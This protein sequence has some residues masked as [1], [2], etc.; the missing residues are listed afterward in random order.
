MPFEKHMGKE[1]KTVKTNVVGKFRD[2]SAQDS[3]VKFQPSDF[4]DDTDSAI[5]VR[6]RTKGSKVESTFARKTGKVVQETQHTIAT[7]PEKTKRP[8]SFSKRE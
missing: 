8:K 3:Q 6:E 5:L 4:H 2:F 1:P 7:L